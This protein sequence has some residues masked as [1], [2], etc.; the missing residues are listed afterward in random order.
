VGHREDDGVKEALGELERLCPVLKWLGS[1]PNT[2][3]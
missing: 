1:Y 2:A 3:L